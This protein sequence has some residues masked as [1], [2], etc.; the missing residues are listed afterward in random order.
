M[1]HKQWLYV[2]YVLQISG[3][4]A[5]LAPLS[6]AAA[7]QL[8]AQGTYGVQTSAEVVLVAVLT[9]SFV[10]NEMNRDNHGCYCICSSSLAV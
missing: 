8:Q 9:G 10:I 5:G 7:A 2:S 3:G 1:T 4:S 6:A